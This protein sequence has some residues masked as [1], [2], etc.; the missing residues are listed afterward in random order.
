[1]MIPNDRLFDNDAAIE[2]YLKEHEDR[3]LVRFIT[4]GSVDDGK[5]TLIGRLLH[6]CK[7][8]FEDQLSAIEKDS[9]KFGTTGTRA[10]LALLVDGL[11][12]E[13]EQ[14]ITIDV[15][16]RYFSTDRRKFIIADTPGHEQYTRNMATGA[17]TAHIAVILIDA[18][19]GVLTQTRRHS[20]I[21]SLLGIKHLV[22]AI[23][24]MDLVNYS[25]QIFE[26]IRREFELQVIPFLPGCDSN[27]QFLPISALEG[28]NIVDCSKNMPFYQG[29]T[30]VEILNTID[31]SFAERFC[32]HDFRFPVQYVNRPHLDFRGYCG[33]IVGGLARVGDKVAVLPSRRISRIKSI[34][35]PAVDGAGNKIAT[36]E[37]AWAPMAV[38]L[39]LED[40]LDVRRGD[41]IVSAHRMPEIADCFEVMLVW[42]NEAPLLPGEK[43]LVKQAGALLNV[44]FRRIIFKKDMNS[45]AELPA[46]RLEINEIACCELHT[47]RPAIVE[48]YEN[49]RNIGAFIVIDRYSNNTLGAGMICRSLHQPETIV[50]G[51]IEAELNAFVRKNF[52]DWS[53]K[54]I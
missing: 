31:T 48:S 35:A 12:S 32:T 53:C 2:A 28:D 4:C 6:D 27:F 33:T 5:S 30:L 38:T 43:Y 26:D 47:D 29:K 45:F 36:V 50:R 42:M 49:N 13:R 8:I 17:S 15:A 41:M 10:D 52:P 16:Y 24:K 46:D 1:M 25:Q 19:K 9:R 18:R 20:Y 14:G 22:V 3:D 37:E 7:M 11:Q 39:T 34:V 44:S 23:N 54:E 51:G 40:E 21:V